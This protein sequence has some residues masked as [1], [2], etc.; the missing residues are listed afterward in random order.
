M[1]RRLQCGA[2][3]LHRPGGH[4]RA[5]CAQGPSVARAG[6]CLLLRAHHILDLAERAPTRLGHCP[7]RVYEGREQDGAKGD[8]RERAEGA[9]EHRKGLAHGEA[10]PKKAQ[11][12][13]HTHIRICT[14]VGG[15]Y[16]GEARQRSWRRRR[17][18]DRAGSPASQGFASARTRSSHERI[19]RPGTCT[20]R[21]RAL[22]EPID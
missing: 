18:T 11:A 12:H 15:P 2:A 19:K 22:G 1:I 10:A 3:A 20:H 4:T 16:S 7:P 5:M 21:H 8:E 14:S 17:T 6:R 13:A 9:G